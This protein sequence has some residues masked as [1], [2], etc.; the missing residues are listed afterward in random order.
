MHTA[1]LEGCRHH[2]F[3]IDSDF[4]TFVFKFAVMLRLL[5]I[6][7]V[8]LSSITFIAA[9]S[10]VDEIWAPSPS[11]HYNGWDPN[12]FD[13]ASYP[14]STPGWARTHTD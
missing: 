2:D 5:Q 9:H 4:F 1:A 13:N 8:T 11:V 14:S 3:R 10:H 7:L 12:F 6:V